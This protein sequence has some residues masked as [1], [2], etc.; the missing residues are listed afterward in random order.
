MTERRQED[1]SRSY[2]EGAC[3]DSVRS[4]LERVKQAIAS[5]PSVVQGLL[6]GSIAVV[7]LLASAC[8]TPPWA[9]GESGALHWYDASGRIVGVHVL[10]GMAVRYG[11]KV[12]FLQLRA[13]VQ[14]N[15]TVPVDDELYFALPNCHGDPYVA[16]GAPMGMLPAVVEELGGVKQLHLAAGQRATRAWQAKRASGY[17]YSLE[18]SPRFEGTRVVKSVPFGV[19]EPL[20]LK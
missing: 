8:G 10:D 19:L 1:K 14:G 2:H 7:A 5:T 15:V 6:F 4:V 18:P 3:D 16:A 20:Q 17:C 11:Q 12:F 9:E 13:D